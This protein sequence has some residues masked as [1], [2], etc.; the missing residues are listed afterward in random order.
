MGWKR[1]REDE[2]EVPKAI[3]VRHGFGLFEHA[4]GKRRLGAA[5][6][7]DKINIIMDGGPLW[8]RFFGAMKKGGEDAAQDLGA[9]FQW[10]TSTDTANFDTDYA[11][12]TGYS[13]SLAFSYFA[14]CWPTLTSA[15]SR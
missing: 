13:F 14:R 8:D 10:V 7:E 11:K 5:H 6:A 12:R 9:Y 4:H 15:A 2:N 1:N 3:E